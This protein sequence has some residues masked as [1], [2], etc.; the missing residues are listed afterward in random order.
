MNAVGERVA[1]R[2]AGSQV[3]ARGK[4]QTDVPD[5]LVLCFT[6]SIVLVLLHSKVIDLLRYMYC[7][8]YLGMMT[9]LQGL[10]LILGK[11]CFPR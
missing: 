8:E 3:S 6:G 10:C 1:S 11:L 5:V 9:I 4:S 7:T 2:D